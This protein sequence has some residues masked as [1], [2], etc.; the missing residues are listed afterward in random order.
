MVVAGTV[1]RLAPGTCDRGAGVQGCAQ[2]PCLAR[3]KWGEI[4]GDR[5]RVR[6]VNQVMDLCMKTF[7]VLVG[8]ES[9][10]KVAGPGPA[11][12]SPRSVAAP[13]T[14]P[15]DRGLLQPERRCQ[16]WFCACASRG[17]CLAL[18]P[19]ILVPSTGAPRFSLTRPLRGAPGGEAWRSK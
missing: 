10:T 18:R 14:A 8:G 13:A 5:E 16:P 15:R 12:S 11:L 1:A 6:N 19:H 3:G 9:Q 2:E 17:W 7:C 4:S